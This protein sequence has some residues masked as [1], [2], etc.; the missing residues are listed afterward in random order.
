MDMICKDETPINDDLE[1]PE[2]GCLIHGMFLE[3]ARWDSH[4]HILTHSNPKELYTIFPLFHLLPVADRVE[5]TENIYMCPI[6][7]VVSRKG[8]LMTTGHSTNFVMYMELPTK[9]DP[10]VWVRAGV[11]GFI[12]LRY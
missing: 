12:S 7:K 6:Y 5:P 2:D 11:A 1:K 3:G 4:K 8:T 9:E 10:R